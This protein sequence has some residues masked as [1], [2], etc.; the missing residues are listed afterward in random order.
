MFFLHFPDR[1]ERLILKKKKSIALCTRE[2]N[3]N[4]GVNRTQKGGGENPVLKHSVE[5]A[6]AF[7]RLLR[8]P[9]AAV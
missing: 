4:D 1:L 3:S 8:L 2:R 5:V 7:L 9:L 6:T